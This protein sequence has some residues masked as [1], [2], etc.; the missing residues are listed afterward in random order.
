MRRTVACALARAGVVRGVL[1]LAAVSGGKDSVC[2]LSILRTLS[3]EIGF[4]L[5]AAHV[6]HGIRE[7]A[8]NDALLAR[9]LCER[10]SVPFFLR[11]VDAPALARE[12]GFSL[13]DAARRLRYAALRDMAKECGADAIVTAHHADDQAETVLMGLVR[14]SAGL[15]RGMAEKT[16]D[17]RGVIVRPMLSIRRDEIERFM[18]ENELP[19]AEDETN[20]DPAYLRNFLRMDLIPSI[21]AHNASFETGA[22]HIAHSL[23]RDDALLERLSQKTYAEFVR[24]SPDGIFFDEGILNEDPALGVRAVRRALEEVGCFPKASAVEEVL[25]LQ[26]KQC[27]RSIDIGENW[28]ARRT[29]Q[30]VAVSKRTQTPTGEFPLAAPGET[31]TPWGVF[32]VTGPRICD[33]P[34]TGKNAQWIPEKLAKDLIVRAM[35]AG[36]RM[37]PLGAKGS[38]LLSDLL[39]DAGYDAASRRKMCVVDSGGAPVWIAGVRGDERCRMRAGQTAYLMEFQAK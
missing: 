26:K 14:G 12:N 13:E 31:K 16:C 11:R 18:S 29:K 10:W 21:R 9:A 28:V 8:H 3:P 20:R 6:E 35:R 2:M 27:G 32:R 22:A 23:R 38:K 7:T 4:S 1:V 39:C 24:T 5:A 36:E 17:A 15:L 30:G 19:F 37:R 25:E 34:K 33:D